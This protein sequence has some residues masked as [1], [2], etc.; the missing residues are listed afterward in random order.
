[1]IFRSI[2]WRLQIWHAALLTC[3]VVGF[4]FTA[5]RLATISRIGQ[6]DQEL[7]AHLAQLTVAVPPPSTGT[8]PRS[9]ERRP[10]PRPG[11]SSIELIVARGAY[12]VIWNNDGSVQTR[13]ANAPDGITRPA[14]TS[15]GEASAMRTVQTTREAIHFTGV[16]RCFLV[17]R[18][19]EAELG[20]LRRL[21]WYLAAVGASVLALGLLGGWWL[22]A[23]AI[24]P[25]AAISETA[26]RIAGGDLSHRIPI[27]AA[28]DEL[29]RL[30]GVLNS[31]FS[32]L[33]A[34][35]AQQAR[36]TA[37]AAHELR[38]PVTAVLM[39]A[40]N[41]L[42]AELLTDEQRE[43]F[44]ACER[45]AQRMK[46]LIESLLDLA[47][48]DADPEPLRRE[49]CD[50]ADITR[51]CVALLRPLAQARRL[52]LHEDLQPA[53]CHG[54]RSRLAQV[55]TNLLTNAIHVTPESGGITLHTHGGESA[56]FT[57][58]DTG[59]GIG[60]GEMP[61]LFERFHRTDASRARATGGTGLGL[62]ICKAV[63]EAHGGTIA[64][65]THPEPG[66]QFKFS[67]PPLFAHS[68]G[69]GAGQTRDGE[70]T[71]R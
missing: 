3:I 46:R 8:E 62:A 34:A 4:G 13:S 19:I 40:Q 1:M 35:F 36:F 18:S 22:T 67:V 64:A 11:A 7:Q 42:S 16:G 70:V 10:P 5:H 38:T 37:D 52:Q 32:K 49:P 9:P 25:I 15:P 41:G 61:C 57:I 21:A 66:A 44:T 54:D 59:P 53:P 55:V 58:T 28:D 6:V 69:R 33:D 63:I 71:R 30:A 23:R 14:R 45:A 65:T 48:L 39:H 60:A 29:A 24:R 17:G 31:T 26:E 47:R 50:L 51:D 2:R 27:A 12:F 20:E 56:H 68:S 43:A